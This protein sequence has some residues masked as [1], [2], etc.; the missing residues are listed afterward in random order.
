M[1]GKNHWLLL[2]T[3]LFPQLLWGIENQPDVAY[4]QMN[5]ES[6]SK[7]S[8]RQAIRDFIRAHPKYAQAHY[9]LHKVLIEDHTPEAYQDAHRALKQALRLEP[10]NITYMIALGDFFSLQDK[11]ALALGQYK[12]VL[13]RSPNE[14]AA[15]VGIGRF[16]L[17]EFLKY[18]HLNI[19]GNK[20]F[21]RKDFQEAVK[22][23]NSA[24]EAHPSY[25]EAYLH[26][27][28][29]YLESNQTE[30]LVALSRKMVRHFPDDWETLTL[31]WLES[32]P[33]W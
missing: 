14:P 20:E 28:V 11:H 7:Q 21:A 17:G 22:Y 18:R 6:L 29:A 33:E 4:D 5:L 8:R 16:H 15:L 24:I 23:F 31:G 19:A 13:K 26:L 9:D 10:R 12:K 27:A 3:F 32:S 1:T 25:R 2:W 30:P